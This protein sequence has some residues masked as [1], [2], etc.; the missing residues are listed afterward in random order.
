MAP[1]GGALWPV[2]RCRPDKKCQY[3]AHFAIS[4]C[5]FYMLDSRWVRSHQVYPWCRLTQ[6]STKH[7][8]PVEKKPSNAIHRRN[9]SVS[10][11]HLQ[12]L[13]SSLIF[14]FVTQWPQAESIT[15][16]IREVLLL[17]MRKWWRTEVEKLRWSSLITRRAVASPFSYTIITFFLPCTRRETT[18]KPDS[19][20]LGRCRTLSLSWL[21]SPL[22]LL[23]DLPLCCNQ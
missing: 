4:L 23:Y 21:L 1:P 5:A 8:P 3:A 10:S 6:S 16:M 7:I 13:L 2:N 11:P 12:K 9:G 20:H 14:H 22:F 18:D 15:I 19:T 17:L